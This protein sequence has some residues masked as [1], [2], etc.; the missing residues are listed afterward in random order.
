MDYMN[1]RTLI[2]SEM[3]QNL[4]RLWLWMERLKFIIFQKEL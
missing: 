3:V 1:F 4:E 2:P